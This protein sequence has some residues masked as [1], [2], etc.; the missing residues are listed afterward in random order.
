MDVALDRAKKQK[1]NTLEQTCIVSQLEALQLAVSN[2]A[3][4]ENLLTKYTL[5]LV[6]EARK[7][8]A[9]LASMLQ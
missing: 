6:H 8:N 7:T 2:L 3:E 9:F 1:A 4:K 5:E